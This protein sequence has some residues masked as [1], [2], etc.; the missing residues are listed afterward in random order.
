M[1]I[2]LITG[3]FLMALVW[4]YREFRNFPETRYREF[5]SFHRKRNSERY[6]LFY[7]FPYVL[8]M[9]NAILLSNFFD[10]S[11][12]I[13]IVLMILFIWLQKT[14]LYFVLK[15]IMITKPDRM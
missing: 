5:L 2:I 13:A 15:V 14:L 11:V 12:W 8:L 10:V 6:S 9:V 7:D 1:K 3:I 4:Y